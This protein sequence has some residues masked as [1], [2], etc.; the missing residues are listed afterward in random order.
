MTAT[1]TRRNKPQIA[2]A[3]TPPLRLISAP[4]AKVT[5]P[6]ARGRP[7]HMKTTT[8]MASYVRYKRDGGRIRPHT[9]ANIRS[10][11]YGFIGQRPHQAAKITK[12]DVVRW[13]RTKDHLATSTL[14]NHVVGARGFC[15]W[16]VRQGILARDPFRDIPTPKVPRSAHRALGPEQ[17]AALLA[18]CIAPRETPCSLGF[19]PG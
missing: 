5:R 11:L 3:T 10:V 12:R 13:M 9:E 2:A 19:T 6:L 1:E 14:R 18:A 8:A 16:L 4:D 7:E 17:V 15:T